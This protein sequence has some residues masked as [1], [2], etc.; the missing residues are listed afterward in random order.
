M[1]GGRAA[2][3]FIRTGLSPGAETGAHDCGPGGL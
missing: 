3:T 1:E 2:V